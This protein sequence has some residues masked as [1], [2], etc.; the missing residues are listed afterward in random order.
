MNIVAQVA[1]RVTSMEYVKDSM[2]LLGYVNVLLCQDKIE[3]PLFSLN[4]PVHQQHNDCEWSLF[5]AE[6]KHDFAVAAEMLNIHTEK[7]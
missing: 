6:V 1:E 2:T 5:A 7:Q 3:L 4:S